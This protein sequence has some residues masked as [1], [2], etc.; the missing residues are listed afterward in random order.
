MTDIREETNQA[1]STTE[2]AA[3]EPVNAL[4]PEADFSNTNVPALPE[5]ST[6]VQVTMTTRDGEPHIDIAGILIGT[7]DFDERNPCHR[8]LAV[9]GKYVEIIMAEVNGGE[10]ADSG[11][12]ANDPHGQA[13]SG[14]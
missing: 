14:E 8:F 9:F 10:L 11:V 13:A 12:A 6:V 1:V 7:Q 5:G 2:Q 4:A 3:N